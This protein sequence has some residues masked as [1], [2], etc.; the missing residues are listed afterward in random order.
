[1]L[2]VSSISFAATVPEHARLA[3]PQASEVVAS[4]PKCQAAVATRSGIGPIDVGPIV[5]P[6]A[7]RADVPH[8]PLFQRE[9]IAAGALE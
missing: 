6:E 2:E 3:G 4:L 7:N 1:M 5:L 8:A 9:V